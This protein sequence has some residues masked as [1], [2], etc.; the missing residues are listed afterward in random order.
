MRTQRCTILPQR[1]RV[2]ISEMIVRADA[3]HSPRA[4]DGKFITVGVKRFR[5]AEVLFPTGISL[6]IQRLTVVSMRRQPVSA[7]TRISPIACTSA[8]GFHIAYIRKSLCC[9]RLERVPRSFERMTEDSTAS[10][11]PEVEVAP[12]HTIIRGSVAGWRRAQE[13]RVPHCK[14]W[15]GVTH[16]RR[17]H[18]CVAGWR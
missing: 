16:C 11:P 4:P 10:A 9:R 13:P 18:R 8:G 5:R 14:E 7:Y 15:P 6:R 1:S 12:S 2:L 3:T 17:D